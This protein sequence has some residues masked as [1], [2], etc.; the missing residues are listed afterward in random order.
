MDNILKYKKFPASEVFEA[1]Q[2]Q[3]ERKI[4][5]VIPIMETLHGQLKDGSGEFCAETQISVIVLYWE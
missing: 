3:G 5:S 1:W 2:R 4:Q